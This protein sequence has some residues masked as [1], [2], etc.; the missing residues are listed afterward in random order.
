MQTNHF[1]VSSPRGPVPVVLTPRAIEGLK[2]YEKEIATYRRELPGWLAEGQGGRSVL[3][4]GDQVL[5]IWE[6]WAEA[7][8]VGRDRFGLEPIFVVP[9]DARDIE[10][11]A[12]L[13]A[14][15]AQQCPL[16]PTS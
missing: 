1:S 14:A 2:L 10:R 7:V 15:L 5:G 3:I 16:S 8:E 6:T 12:L 13:D 9:I 4:R 11:Y